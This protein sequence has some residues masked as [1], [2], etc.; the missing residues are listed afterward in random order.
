METPELFPSILSDVVSN[1][2]EIE[3][4]RL[5]AERRQ[6][7]E[8][9]INLDTRWKMNES[10]LAL[11]GRLDQNGTAEPVTIITLMEAG[12][13]AMK[14]LKRFTRSELAQR[15]R[16]DNPNLEFSEGSV[17]KPIKKGIDSRNVRMVQPHQ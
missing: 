11:L 16:L 5:E 1:R 9:R 4:K 13:T 6:L 14:A 7:V 10:N 3:R 17:V 8:E 15:I 2:F 12:E